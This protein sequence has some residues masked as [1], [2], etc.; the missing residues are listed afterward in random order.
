MKPATRGGTLN[1][2]TEAEVERIHSASIFLLENH[3]VFSESDLILDIFEKASAWV[4]RENRIIRLPAEMVASAMQSAPASFTFFGRDPQYDILLEQGP[5]YFGMGGSSE[6]F[7]WD[8]KLGKPRLPT[9][10]DMVTCTRVGQAALNIDF[11][12]ALCSAGDYPAKQVFL[13]EYD[14]L[15][16]NTTKPILYS[17]PNRWHTRIFI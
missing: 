9:K 1:V 14:A 15:F 6:P 4:D 3:G 8:Y 2:L 12:M 7:Y 17:C 13:Q 16:R 5:L 10:A 11:I